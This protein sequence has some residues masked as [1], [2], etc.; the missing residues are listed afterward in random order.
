MYK[1]YLSPKT[2]RLLLLVFLTLTS[3]AMRPLPLF[4]DTPPQTVSGGV[5]FLAI[6]G[7]LLGLVFIVGGILLM[8]RIRRE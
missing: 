8:I 2:V 3:L 5:I 1:K 6:A 7:I 4:Q